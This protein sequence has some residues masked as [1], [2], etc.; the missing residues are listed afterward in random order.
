MS[1]KRKSYSAEFKTKVVLETLKG[2]E[3]VNQIA[4]KYEIIPNMISS[5]RSEFMK[6]CSMVF[7]KN[8]AEKRYQDMKKEFEK[9]EDKL[10]KQ[11]GELSV[12]VNWAQKKIR[13][14]G[15]DD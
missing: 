8:D 6:S 2:E 5:W 13:E 1:L 12:M 10:V 3:T 11:I 15:L 14:A 7:E 9:K 4:A